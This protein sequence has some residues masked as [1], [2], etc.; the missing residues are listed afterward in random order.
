MPLPS[1]RCHVFAD[2]A[3]GSLVSIAVLVDSGLFVDLL[4]HALH[5]RDQYGRVLLFG[6]RDQN[7]RLWRIPLKSLTVPPSVST[8]ATATPRLLSVTNS[9]VHTANS[10]IRH[11]TNAERAF[12]AYRTMGSPPLPTLLAAMDNCRIVIPGINAAMVRQNRPFHP[13]EAKGHLTTV[14]QGL[15]STHPSLP[16]LPFTTS[17]PTDDVEDAHHPTA[18]PAQHVYLTRIVELTSRQFMDA[19][20]G[21]FPVVSR[22][23]NRIMLVIYDYDSNYIHV[24]LLKDNSASQVRDAYARALLVFRMA[25]FSPSFLR[26]DNAT[27]DLLQAFAT[28]EKLTL[29]YVPP[30]NHRANIA[31][32]AIRTWKAHFLSVVTGADPTFPLQEWD[33]LIPQA[34]LTLNLLRSS[35][36]FP[37]LSAYQVLHGAFDWNRTPLA[38]AGT[39]ILVH[40]KPKNRPAWAER[41]I[42]A[43]YVGPAL[44]HYRCF[45]VFVPS[46]QGVRITDTIAWHPRDFVMPHAD[47]IS[48][49]T[50][51]TTD[52]AQALRDVTAAL[53][54]PDL[55]KRALPLRTAA[56][57]TYRALNDLYQAATD[58]HLSPIPPLPDAPAPH[59]PT[60]PQFAPLAAT[61]RVATMS[62]P[63]SVPSQRVLTST[64]LPPVSPTPDP[65]QRVAP[66]PTNLL[67]DF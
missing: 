14:R 47:P 60:A 53:A 1:R 32:R 30:G 39:R 9:S 20:G 35:R 45:S 34:V 48:Q 41:G 26:L 63:S 62:P 31:E 50:L 33:L 40:I 42:P 6:S 25:G 58:K 22:S 13:S 2:L 37:R 67:S 7:T 12:F 54:L 43:F 17:T 4:P 56:L 3:S 65:R 19:V 15:R 8:S 66:A 57:D 61:Q 38:P 59:N 23:G 29:E 28:K 24:E 16:S 55:G 46:S 36:V 10:V 51:A 18:E 21:H 27:S 49:L 5:V 52:H 64:L 11:E 44:Q